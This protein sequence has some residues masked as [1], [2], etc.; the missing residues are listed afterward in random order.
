MKN[1]ATILMIMATAPPV[2]AGYILQ[3]DISAAD[4]AKAQITTTAANVSAT[5]PTAVGVRTRN[6]RQGYSGILAARNWPSGSSLAPD[7]Y[8]EFSVTAVPGYSVS[9][10]S[11]TLALFRD[12]RRA[13]SHGAES[14]ELHA[15][16]DGF[17]TS[18]VSLL[19]FDISGSAPNEQIVFLDQ[20]V[21]ALGTQVGTVS[22][23]LYGY[24][25]RGSSVYAGLANEDGTYLTG[26]GSALILEGLVNS[27]I[28]GPEPM[29]IP[30]LALG[31]GPY[32]LYSTR[33]RRMTILLP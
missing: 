28:P 23:R 1:V 4:G 18:D 32:L 12:Y 6:P 3:Y 5:T 21:S 20:E 15:S 31:A 22:F 25:R 11:I 2:W 26:T 14:W 17:S 27:P 7:K 10:D 30:F 9:Y 8:F 24:D 33:K 29:T 13:N 19:S 16:P